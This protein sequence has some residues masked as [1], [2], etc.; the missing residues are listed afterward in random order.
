ML[1][2]NFLDSA[3]CEHF[4]KLAKRRL[5]KSDLAYKPGEKPQDDQQTRTSS[6]TFLSAMDDPDGV[7]AWVEEK[8]A[9]VTFVPREHGEVRGGR[10]CLAWGRRVL[11]MGLEVLM[12][13]Y[14]CMAHSPVRAGWC[15]AR[16]MQ[17]AACA[18]ALR[19]ALALPWAG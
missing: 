10:G 9:S 16:G 11:F 6:G 12:T 3:R 15:K 8:I 18:L 7:L 14:T 13:E 5:T 1:Y 4:I 17:P 19:A 2:P